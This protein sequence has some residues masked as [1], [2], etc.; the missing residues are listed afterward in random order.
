MKIIAIIQARM[1]STR[2]PGKVMMEICGKPV[3][4]HVVERVKGSEYIDKIIVATGMG[5]ANDRIREYC[6]NNNIDIY[7]GS[8]EDVLDRYYRAALTHRTEA[9]DLIVR[10]TA[11]CPLIDPEIIDKVIEMQISQNLEYTSNVLKLTFP[12]GL[13]CEV[14]KFSALEKAWKDATLKSEREHVTQYIIKHPEIFQRSN[15]ENNEDLSSLRWTLDEYEDYVLI[16]TVYEKLY[17]KKP[18]F[19]INDIIGLFNEELDLRNNNSAYSRNEGL[20]KSLSEDDSI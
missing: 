5:E 9:D 14:F 4:Q 19:L 20:T 2:L 3:L 17:R 15:F 8:E 6:T 16:K 7:S 13:D 1:G 10:I 11:D 18:L 12:D